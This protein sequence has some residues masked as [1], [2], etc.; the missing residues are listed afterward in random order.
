M[1]TGRV[2]NTPSLYFQLLL[3]FVVL[4]MVKNTDQFDFTFH[5]WSARIISRTWCNEW[6]CA[7]QHR[8]NNMWSQKHFWLGVPKSSFF[9]FPLSLTISISIILKVL[10][11]FLFCL[12]LVLSPGLFC[13]W[14]SAHWRHHLCALH[15]RPGTL[16]SY[17]FGRPTNTTVLKVSKAVQKWSKSWVTAKNTWNMDLDH[18]RTH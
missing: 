13:F 3:Q 6:W 4:R 11:S 10:F 5:T 15:S 8:Y 16:S 18:S 2:K 17:I 1:K 14:S 7:N 12:C 9:L